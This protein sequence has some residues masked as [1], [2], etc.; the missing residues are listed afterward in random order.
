MDHSFCVQSL[1]PCMQNSDAKVTRKDSSKN[2]TNMS[3]SCDQDQG[4]LSLDIWKNAF[5][6]AC[7]RLC[8]IRAGGHECGCLS[9]LPRLV[10]IYLSISLFLSFNIFRLKVLKFFII[11]PFC[12]VPFQLPFIC[13]FSLHGS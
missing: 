1:T 11:V 13:R 4:N 10:S 9:V 3:G 6:E 7:E 12:I 8:P 5:R 2:Y